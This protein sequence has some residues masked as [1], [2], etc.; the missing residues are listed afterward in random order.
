MKDVV[1]KSRK[2]MTMY[3]AL[4]LKIYID[5]L[6]IKR[7]EGG[8]VMMSLEPCAGEEKNSVVFILPI[9]KKTSSRKLMQ[10]NK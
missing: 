3:G 6:C 1:R 8:C 9:L 4:H 2:T 10:V 7:K 5:R